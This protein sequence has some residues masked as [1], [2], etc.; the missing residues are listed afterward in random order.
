MNHARYLHAG[1]EEERSGRIVSKT[2][3][4]SQIMGHFCFGIQY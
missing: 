3:F 1:I 4:L 2:L